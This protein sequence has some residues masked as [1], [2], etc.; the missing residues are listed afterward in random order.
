[1]FSL[2]K[3]CFASP[4]YFFRATHGLRGV[5]TTAPGISP[6]LQ[7]IKILDLTRVLAGPLCTQLLADLGADVIKIEERSRG[8]DTR[9]WSPPSAAKLEHAETSHLPA[10]SAYFLSV[11]RNKRSVTVD[12]KK[13]KGLQILHKMVQRSDVLVENF[14]PDKLATMGLGWE[15][16]HRLNPRLIY[17][18]ITGIPGF[19]PAASV[20]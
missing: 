6:P 20:G 4:S 11:N 10:E 7:S 12:F 15:E 17:C 14:L 16:C 19:D 13:K 2:R 1:M 5:S 8:D 9:S 18:S 3:A